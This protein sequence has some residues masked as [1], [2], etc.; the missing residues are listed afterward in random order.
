MKTLNELI[1]ETN[2][3]R[4]KV[5]FNLS[6]LKTITG[7]S[8]RA[9]KYRM[10]LVKRKYCNIPALL[11]KKNNKWEI[12]YTIIQDFLPKYKTTKSNIY[13]YDWRSVASWNP[14]ADY[15]VQYHVEIVKQIKEQL[16]KIT[17]AY[18]VEQDGRGVNH[19][20]IVANV[21]VDILNNAVVSTILK[22]ID[23]STDC[24]IL[25]EPIQNKYCAIEYLK[26]API[27]SGII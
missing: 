11:T 14:L 2:S 12:H 6:E 16:P 19:T 15:D 18:A 10:L 4:I 22:Y 5:F 7:L 13:N 21:D 3:K 26:K 27:A 17:I 20:H 8:A 24:K 1:N 23:R 25:V 9:L